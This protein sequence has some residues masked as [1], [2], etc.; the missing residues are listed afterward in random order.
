[1]ILLPIWIKLSTK[2]HPRKAEPIRVGP[3]YSAGS[4]SY[5]TAMLWV[6]VNSLEAFRL[7]MRRSMLAAEAYTVK[8]C[9]VP[10][11]LI[12]STSRTCFPASF[13]YRL[14]FS[15]ACYKAF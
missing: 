2:P 9:E 5:L 3:A 1:M 12:I 14:A 4:N 13:A 15:W 10:S 8:P 11:P 6:K 7:E